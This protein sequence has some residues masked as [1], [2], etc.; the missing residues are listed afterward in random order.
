M[1]RVRV[2][3]NLYQLMGEGSNGG[4]LG[5]GDG[6]GGLGTGEKGGGLGG[7]EIVK[8][9]RSLLTDVSNNDNTRTTFA[10]T[11][12]NSHENTPTTSTTCIDGTCLC[13]CRP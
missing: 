10:P 6:G 5:G 2:E 3:I 13:K 8:S 7:G 9:W 1:V 11:T 12:T 4:G